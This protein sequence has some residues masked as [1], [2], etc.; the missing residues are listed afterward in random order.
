ME[1]RVT[2][3]IDGDDELLG[4]QVFQVINTEYRR[5]SANIV[6]GNFIEYHEDR[7]QLI[8]GFST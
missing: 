3:L 8:L 7:A 5:S 1:K 2:V 4:A 6:Y